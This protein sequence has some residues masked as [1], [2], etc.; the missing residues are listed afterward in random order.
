MILELNLQLAEDLIDNFVFRT[1]KLINYP[2][3]CEEGDE[4][5]FDVSIN[6]K[7]LMFMFYAI[8]KTYI[9]TCVYLESYKTN[10]VI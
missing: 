6:K 10:N 5:K 9:H 8:V 2:N 3:A 4:F 7:N 1:V